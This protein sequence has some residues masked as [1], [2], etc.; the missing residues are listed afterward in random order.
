MPRAPDRAATFLALHRLRQLTGQE[1]ESWDVVLDARRAQAA[2]KPDFE[3]RL[4][5]GSSRTGKRELVPVG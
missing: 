2:P 1:R 3:L 4:P 5:D